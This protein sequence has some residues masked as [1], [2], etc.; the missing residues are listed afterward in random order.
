MSLL[1]ILKDVNITHVKDLNFYIK[2]VAVVNIK[3]YIYIYIYEY[4]SGQRYKLLY[5]VSS[6]GVFRKVGHIHVINK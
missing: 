6:S 4:Y 5:K 3:R 2:L 1:L